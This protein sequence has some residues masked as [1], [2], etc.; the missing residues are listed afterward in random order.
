MANEV[1]VTTSQAD[2]AKMIVDR[3]SVNGKSTPEAIRKIAEAQAD[4]APETTNRRR[5][6]AA[7]SSDRNGR[8][9][10]FWAR[11]SSGRA[12]PHGG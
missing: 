2:A 11:I 10:A 9:R 3:N 1:R 12:A 7:V 5:P 4:P 8:L 6:K